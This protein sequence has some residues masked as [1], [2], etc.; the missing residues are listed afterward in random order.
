M[1]LEIIYQDFTVISTIII[2]GLTL[3]LCGIIV[4]IAKTRKNSKQCYYWPHYGYYSS[5]LIGVSLIVFLVL[6]ENYIN[7][8]I[9]V[10]FYVPLII[11]SIIFIISLYFLLNYFIFKMEIKEGYLCIRS[12]FGKIK[13][14]RLDVSYSRKLIWT[15]YHDKKKNK[16]YICCHS[17]FNL[18]EFDEI[19]KKLNK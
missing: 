9:D 16:K 14:H 4:Y 18:V 6:R 19:L 12:L 8:C 17:N 7:N 11:F 5:I 2:G 13:I 1:I 15:I 3:L 10:Y